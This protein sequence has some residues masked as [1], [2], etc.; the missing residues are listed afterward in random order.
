MYPS[1]V[2]I[3]IKFS[4]FLMS[5]ALVGGCSSSDADADPNATVSKFC[6]NWGKAA[7]SARTVTACSGAEQATEALTNGCSES[8]AAFCEGLLPTTGYNPSRAV[9]CLNAVKNAYSDGNL[10][11]AELDTVRHRGA[12]CDHLVKGAQGK[13]GSCTSNDDC[14]TVQNYLCILKSGEG[15]CEI[16][17]VVANGTSCAAPEASCNDGFYCDG[18]NCVQSRAIAARCAADFECATGLICDPDTLKC[19]ARVSQTE[20]TKDNDCTTNVCSIPVGSGTGRCVSTVIL[21]P[22]EGLCLDLRAQ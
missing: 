22:S 12:P 16:P 19:V 11:A 7:C 13:G 4:A 9:E 18:A 3:A 17:T 14:D 21:A 10:S 15:S 1:H 6:A 5:L 20:C 8:Q 2:T